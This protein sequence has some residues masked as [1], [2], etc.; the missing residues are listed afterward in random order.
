MGRDRLVKDH[1]HGPIL[2]CSGA[3]HDVH[4]DGIRR[5]LEPLAQVPIQYELYGKAFA[6]H[7]R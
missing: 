1:G 6:V 4:V 2:R 3:G 5:G 7:A